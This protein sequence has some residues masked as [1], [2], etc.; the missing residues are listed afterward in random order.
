MKTYS[1]YLAAGVPL[2]LAVGGKV[3]YVQRSE[4]GQVL[5]IEFISGVKS[6]SIERVGKGFKAAPAGGFAAIKITA[7]ESGTVDFVVTDGEI[8]VKFDDAATVIGND[9]SQAIPVRLQDGARMAV[10]IAGGNVQLTATSV[11]IS[12]TDDL[13]IPIRQRAADVFAVRQVQQ[14]KIIDYDPTPVGTAGVL[15][16]KDAALRGVRFRNPHAT[17]R[18]ALGG[19]A[20]TM[21]NAVILLEPGDIWNETD[22]PGAEW[23][24]ISDTAGASVL[25]QGLKA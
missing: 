19:A 4:A 5:K 10:D 3:L 16:V 17:A 2:Q 11:G 15:L 25:V 8:D 18:I 7:S 14:T 23:H 13:A 21:A 22:A 6:E 12:N 9:D 1:E 24:A 20:V